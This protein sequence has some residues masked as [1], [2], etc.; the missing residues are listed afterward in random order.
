[1]DIL[2]V[3]KHMMQY[4]EYLITPNNLIQTFTKRLSEK[5][6]I[7]MQTLKNKPEIV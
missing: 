7:V 1:M 6:S 4:C 5:N 3:M 2:E